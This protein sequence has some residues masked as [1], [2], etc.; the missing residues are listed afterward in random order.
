MVG[1]R[2]LR[3]RGHAANRVPVVSLERF[4]R[5]AIDRAH[6][7][8]KWSPTWDFDRAVGATAEWY[9]ERHQ[10]GLS[11]MYEFSRHQLRDFCDDARK[12]KAA[13]TGELRK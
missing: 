3:A 9:R 2:I 13:W 8:L 12:R 7:V 1:L 5:Y 10:V 6:A 11:D 4:G